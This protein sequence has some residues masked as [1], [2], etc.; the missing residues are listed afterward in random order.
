MPKDFAQRFDIKPLFNT[1]RGKCM[2]QRMKI[3]VIQS[4]F[5]KALLEVFPVD[6]RFNKTPHMGCQKIHVR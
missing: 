5:I 4:A 6:A 1:A 3:D 2:A